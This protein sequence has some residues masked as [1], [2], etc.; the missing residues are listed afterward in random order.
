MPTES[1]AVL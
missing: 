1:C